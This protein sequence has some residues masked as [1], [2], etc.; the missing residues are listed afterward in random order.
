MGGISVGRGG[1]VFF[2]FF[3]FWGG[4]GGVLLGGR[5]VTERE[6]TVYGGNFGEGLERSDAERGFGR[7]WSGAKRSIAKSRGAERAK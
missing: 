6:F 5:A 2:F 3:F 7:D 1:G 4:G